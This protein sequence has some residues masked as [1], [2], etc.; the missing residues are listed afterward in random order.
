MSKWKVHVAHSVAL[1]YAL[2]VGQYAYPYSVQWPVVSKCTFQGMLPV[3]KYLFWTPGA[4]TIAEHEPVDRVEIV[5]MVGLPVP[6][7]LKVEVSDEYLRFNKG[8]VRCVVL[9]NLFLSL[10]AT[11]GFGYYTWNFNPTTPATT[12]LF[13]CTSMSGCEEEYLRLAGRYLY[14]G[15]YWDETT[16]SIPTNVPVTVSG[17]TYFILEGVHESNFG[18]ISSDVHPELSNSGD[19]G[20]SYSYDGRR[21]RMGSYYDEFAG[22]SVVNG[23]LFNYIRGEPILAKVCTARNDVWLFINLLYNTFLTS[24]TA[25]FLVSVLVLTL[26]GCSSREHKERQAST[27]ANSKK[28]TNSAA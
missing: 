27:L 13:M 17:C 15:S 18:K 7:V 19:G 10:G 1:N 3:Y 22:D 14:Q 4:W 28:K 24:Q 2:T 20:D 8:A 5:S 21:R 9:L 6:E 25:I 11:A 23:T 26:G 12:D 16:L